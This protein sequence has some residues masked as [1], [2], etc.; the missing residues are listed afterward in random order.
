[1]VR[2]EELTDASPV[3]ADAIL[4][5]EMLSWARFGIGK[6]GLMVVVA[7][8][9]SEPGHMNIW[10]SRK[11]SRR[12]LAPTDR[13]RE[14]LSHIR[15][16]PQMKQERL[17]VLSRGNDKPTSG[18]IG[19]IQALA[20][21]PRSPTYAATY[22]DGS[23]SGQHNGLNHFALFDNRREVSDSMSFRRLP[24]RLAMSERF[25]RG[26]VSSIPLPEHWIPRR[27]PRYSGTQHSREPTRC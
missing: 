6:S 15:R 24:Q 4:P 22:I 14:D 11:G 16:S 9:W 8:N 25:G 27:C 18:S 7:T 20:N 10:R 21:Y 17:A 19:S 1:M 5:W 13:R 26:H 2:C 23:S 12:R 3:L